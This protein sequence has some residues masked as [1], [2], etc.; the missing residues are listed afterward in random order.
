MGTNRESDPCL[1]Q[2]PAHTTATAGTVRTARSA[3]TNQ[4]NVNS[5]SGF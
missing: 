5:R 2:L 3:T 4:K 1:F